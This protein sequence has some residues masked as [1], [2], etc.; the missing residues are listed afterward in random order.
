MRIDH[1]LD[2]LP[3]PDKYRNA[4]AEEM[5]NG[6]YLAGRWG[7]SLSTEEFEKFIR[8]ADIEDVAYFVLGYLGET[9]KRLIDLA[10]FYKKHYGIVIPAK[11]GILTVEYWERW[12]RTHA[13]RIREVAKAFGKKIN[14]QR[15]R[16]T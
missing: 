11:E 5:G 14:E 15:R 4:Y 1:F 2:S 6:N 13:G 7:K 8:Q 12:A 10:V 3:C 16:S 9:P